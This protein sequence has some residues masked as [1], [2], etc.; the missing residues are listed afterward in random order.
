[1]G[2]GRSSRTPFKHWVL[3]KHLGKVCGVLSVGSRSVPAVA[4]P[5]LCVDLCAG[6]GVVTDEH[7]SS[8]S[9]INRHCNWL[10]GRNGCSA[11]ATFIERHEATFDEL[12]RNVKS[13]ECCHEVDLVCGDSRDFFLEPR[14]RS[15][16]IFVNCDPNS[17]A[18]MPLAK[19]FALSLTPS[20]T[21]TMTLGCN[22]GGLKRM[23]LENRLAWYDYL[24][25][26]LDGI[27]SWHDAILIEVVKDPAQW[28]YF[29]RVPSKWSSGIVKSCLSH[30][31]KVFPN[32][33]EVVTLRSDRDAFMR[34]Q[35][36][37]FLTKKELSHAS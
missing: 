33:V 34:M 13:V 24:E 18:D 25:V 21:M 2:V 22:V 17:I 7:Q 6:D 11:K 19:P 36:R 12:Y 20:T 5:F 37:L 35:D 4:N 30:G 26:L 29:S 10:H 28:A 9:I 1:M 32:G 31:G 14:S 16:A 8:P 15:Q 3:D 27:P 23:P